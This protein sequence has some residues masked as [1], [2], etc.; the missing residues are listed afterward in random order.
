M[1]ATNVMIGDQ[2]AS[3]Y[4]YDDVSEGCAF[5]LQGAG[6]RMLITTNE[7]IYA[8]PVYKLALRKLAAKDALLFPAS[9]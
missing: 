6:A 9:D 8:L 7:P 5:A 1:N 2:R 4:G 3:T